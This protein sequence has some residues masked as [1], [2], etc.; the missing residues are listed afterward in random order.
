MSF[1]SRTSGAHSPS[2]SVSRLLLGRRTPRHPIRWRRDSRIG[3]RD[4]P[5]SHPTEVT[6][7]RRCAMSKPAVAGPGVTTL[8]KGDGS[9]SS[10]RLM[11][12]S[13]ALTA[14]PIRP[15]VRLSQRRRLAVQ[16]IGGG[17]VALTTQLPLRRS[18]SGS[19]RRSHGQAKA[20][21]VDGSEVHAELHARWKRPGVLAAGL[22]EQRSDWHDSCPDAAATHLLRDAQPL[23]ARSRGWHQQACHCGQGAIAASATACFCGWFTG[24]RCRNGRKGSSFLQGRSVA[25]RHVGSWKILCRLAH[26]W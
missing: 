22:T 15:T 25:V 19:D 17:S 11:I 2:L 6:Y 21:G 16:A 24:H 26:R 9:K 23:C 13:G 18:P 4:L 1:D 20:V 12:R 5:S 8:R 7:W 10:S 3:R 14:L